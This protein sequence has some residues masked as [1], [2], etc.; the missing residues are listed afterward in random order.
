MLSLK[1]LS[2][3]T[4]VFL[5]LC[6]ASIFFIDQS[7]VF[8]IDEHLSFLQPFVNEL[9]L[10]T[11][12]VTGYTISKYFIVGIVLLVGVIMLA[13]DKNLS[14]AKYF[15]FISLTEFTSRLV[16]GMLKNVFERARPSHLLESKQAGQTFWI[17]G[18]DSF[19]SGHVGHYFAIF[20][21]LMVLFPKQR[22][23]LLIVPL[24]IS[25]GRLILNVHYL[26]D[27]LTSVYLV[28]VF[29]SLFGYLMKIHQRENVSVPKQS[30]AQQ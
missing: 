21:P 25:L 17:A 2:Y 18:G 8:F 15:F 26:S 9:T 29:T 19:P 13:I 14:R 23:L 6:L 11:D 24:Y 27:V 20:L 4:A 16:V 1:Q 3:L 28:I 30:E 10:Y 5:A 7:L 12:I 22:L